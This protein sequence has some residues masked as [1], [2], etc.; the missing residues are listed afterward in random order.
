MLTRISALV[1]FL[2]KLRKITQIIAVCNQTHTKHINTVNG[3]KVEYLGVRTDCTSSNH[4][5]SEELIHAYVY[6]CNSVPPRMVFLR[7]E[8]R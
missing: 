2:C 8:R 3:Q 7:T 4:C 1:G 5:G 6:M